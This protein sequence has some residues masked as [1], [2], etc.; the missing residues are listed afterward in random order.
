MSTT[1]MGLCWPLQ[2]PPTPKSVLMS[3]ADNANDHGQCWPSLSKITERTCFGKT[4]VIEAIRWLEEHGTLTAD[5]TNGRHTSYVLTPDKF[6]LNLSATRTGTGDVP[7]RQT[8]RTGTGD[9]QDLSATRTGPVR[10]ADTNHK[11]PPRAKSK[12]SSRDVQKLELPAWLPAEAWREFV[13]HRRAIGKKLGTD[14][15]KQL[16][17]G[18]LEKLRSAG[19]DPRGVIDQSIAN[20]WQGLFEIKPEQQAR[21]GGRD[22]FRADEPK[23]RTA[24]RLGSDQ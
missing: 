15:A 9:G 3:L 20:G 12:S 6:S 7:V 8:D 11:E 13:A 23:P 4:A 16:A 24:R 5:R 10:E 19:H 2:M 21:P 17:I 1:V 18:K 14:Y 22:L